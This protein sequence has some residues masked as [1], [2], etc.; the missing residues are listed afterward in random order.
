MAEQTSDHPYTGKWWGDPDVRA[1][2][3]PIPGPDGAIHR[4][5]FTVTLSW[6][7]SWDLSRRVLLADAQAVESGQ[8]VKDSPESNWLNYGLTFLCQFV[9]SVSLACGMLTEITGRVQ[10]AID[11]HEPVVIPDWLAEQGAGM[12]SGELPALA[13]GYLT[14][15]MVHDADEHD[16]VA[17]RAYGMLAIR[18]ALV[19]ARDEFHELVNEETEPEWFVPGVQDACIA[20]SVLCAGIGWGEELAPSKV[21]EATRYVW[22]GERVIE[23]LR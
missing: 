5:P 19:G 23:L 13:A 21:V 12:A 1:Y 14:Q 9:G 15:R 18:A 17:S 11:S 20:V 3:D 22:P 10:Q 4:Q 8:H 2:P 7:D 16:E 6:F